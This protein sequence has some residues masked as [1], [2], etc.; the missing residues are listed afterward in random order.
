MHPNGTKNYHVEGKTKSEYLVQIWKPVIQP[1][2]LL[3]RM[4]SLRGSSHFCCWFHGYHIVAKRC[5]SGS[6][7]A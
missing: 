6:I 2:D 3:V 1:A 7:P 4:A 5:Q